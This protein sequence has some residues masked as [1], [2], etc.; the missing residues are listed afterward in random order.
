MPLTAFDFP[1]LAR[2]V[3]VVETMTGQ[4]LPSFDGEEKNSQDGN[5]AGTTTTGA[6]TTGAPLPKGVVLGPD[7]KP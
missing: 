6:T 3:C 2:F 7:G 4:P 5:H 1:I